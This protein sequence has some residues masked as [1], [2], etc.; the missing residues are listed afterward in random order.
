VSP[1]AAGKVLNVLVVD[2]QQVTEGDVLALIGLAA[3]HARDY[4]DGLLRTARFKQLC[5][6]EQLRIDE[7]KGECVITTA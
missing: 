6:P 1:Q 7:A 5:S 3:F 2:N 4:R